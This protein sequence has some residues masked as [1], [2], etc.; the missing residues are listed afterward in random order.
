MWRPHYFALL[1]LLIAD[2]CYFPSSTTVS[3]SVEAT[4]AQGGWSFQAPS[5]KGRLRSSATPPH[6]EGVISPPQLFSSS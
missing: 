5:M 3:K 6:P 4:G 2:S 1:A